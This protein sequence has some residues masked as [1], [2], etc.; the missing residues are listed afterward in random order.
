MR[1]WGYMSQAIFYIAEPVYA[2][3]QIIRLDYNDFF[4][5][6]ESPDVHFLNLPYFHNP[7]FHMKIL[8]KYFHLLSAKD[9]IIY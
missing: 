2:G 1:S 7:V 3:S 5:T 4:F 8:V 9:Q 6:Y